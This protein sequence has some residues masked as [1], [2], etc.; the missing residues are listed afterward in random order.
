MSEVLQGE[1]YQKFKLG[2]NL[3]EQSM[4]MSRLSNGDRTLD[5]NN[6][7]NTYVRMVQN[8]ERLSTELCRNQVELVVKEG[9]GEPPAAAGGAA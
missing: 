2:Q 6:T 5:E 8:Q 3:Y 7:N 4:T 9:A 1:Y